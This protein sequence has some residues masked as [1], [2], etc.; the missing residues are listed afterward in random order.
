MSGVPRGRKEVEA[1]RFLAG[2]GFWAQAASRAY[3]AAFYVAEE[4]LLAMGESRSSH[5]GVLAA[6]GRL[7]VREG[8]LDPEYGRILRLLFESRNRADYDADVVPREQADAAI[9]DAER[10]VDAVEA[11]LGERNG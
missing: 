8:G 5:S 6:F 3:Y 4:A 1:A 7:I 11:W 9:A 2:G 10:F